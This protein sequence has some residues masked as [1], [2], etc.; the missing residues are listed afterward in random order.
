M[1]EPRSDQKPGSGDSTISYCSYGFQYIRKSWLALVREAEG[2]RKGTDPEHVHRMRVA[3]RRLRAAM[4]IF[5]SCFPVKK[6]RKWLKEIKNITASLGDARDLDVQIGFLEEYLHER[7][8]HLPEREAGDKVRESGA[9]NV[10]ALLRLLQQKRERLQKAV[11]A[12]GISVGKGGEFDEFGVALASPRPG[13]KGIGK[14]RAL[15]RRAQRKISSCIDDLL[16]YE[17]AVHDP[18]AVTRHHEMRIAAKRLRYTLEAFNRFYSGELKKPV[19]R[20]RALQDVLGQMHD[21]DVWIGYLPGFMQES[22]E[23]ESGSP[24]GRHIPGEG[25]PGIPGLLDD[26]K[27]ERARLYRAFVEMWDSLRDA[28]FFETLQERIAQPPP[29]PSGHEIHGC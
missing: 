7:G 26:R 3:S 4:P 19:G 10:S 9:T 15:H 8:L 29:E 20:V 12:A 2:A 1:A 13:R 21:C 25:R 11:E 16:A 28:R 14:P 18:D 23:T 6:Y 24:Q 27:Q 22:Q 17:P 5:K